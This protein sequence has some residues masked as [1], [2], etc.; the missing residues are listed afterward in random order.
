MDI[1]IL[2]SIFIAI[3]ILV[4]YF[5]HSGLVQTSNFMIPVTFQ[6]FYFI[7]VKSKLTVTNPRKAFAVNLCDTK[8][9]SLKLLIQ[10]FL[11]TVPLD[12]RDEPLR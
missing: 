4:S 11:S 9:P 10:L 8:N 2:V 12:E 3:I 6:S 5:A 7:K 1:L